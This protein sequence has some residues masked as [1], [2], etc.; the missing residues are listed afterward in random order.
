[1]SAEVRERRLLVES[2][3]PMA[4]IQVLDGRGVVLAR[5]VERLSVTLPCGYYIIRHVA[6]SE[7]KE[8]LLELPPGPG[9]LLVDAPPFDLP[10]PRVP[11]PPSNPV[12]SPVLLG[13]LSLT[14][15]FPN[16]IPELPLYGELRIRDYDGRQLALLSQ[17]QLNSGEQWVSLN[18]APG[19]YL[20]QSPSGPP[21]ER[22]TTIIEQCLFVGA[23]WRTE[24]MVPA[25]QGFP[26]AGNA[27][28]FM[29]RPVDGEPGPDDFSFAELARQTLA[30]SRSASASMGAG[31]IR[32]MLGAKFEN[33]MLGIYG[34][35]LL[36]RDPQYDR[37]LLN[38]VI[39]NLKRLVGRHPDVLSL[40]LLDNDPGDG[41]IE[42]RWP[43]MLRSSWSLIVRKGAQSGLIPQGSYVSR[44]G[45]NLWGA[46]AWLEWKLP[47]SLDDF[48]EV[49]FDRIDLTQLAHAAAERGLTDPPS[50]LS[51]MELQL[52]SY[53]AQNV[54]VAKRSISLAKEIATSKD[55]ELPLGSVWSPILR[56]VVP[57][58]L[59]A[60]TRGTAYRL[61]QPQ[62]VA[63]SLG[64]PQALVAWA[65]SSLAKK[66]GLLP[67]GRFFRG[68]DLR[69]ARDRWSR[70][71]RI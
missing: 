55:R 64:V 67:R 63:S 26:D 70:Q 22:Q 15:T 51:P 1:M 54:A 42:F 18:L 71:T 14:L 69:S 38:E 36:I 61:L 49:S 2:T 52:Y 60:D 30:S 40:C 53:L 33:P 5:A 23:G 28:V 9:D 21:G 27:T 35:H 39:G 50:D 41:P 59:V 56:S 10:V 12:V 62:E 46:S 29:V 47:R 43:P 58:G 44:I 34:A 16:R 65:A 31:S 11:P 57:S 7:A 68:A 32:A 24:V 37:G 48:N 13:E 6:G 19:C 45:A 4:E 3:Y 17:E 20:L 8:K 25:R 66:L